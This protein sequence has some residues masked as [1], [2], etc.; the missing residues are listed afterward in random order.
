MGLAEPSG[1]PLTSR[2]RS[3]TRDSVLRRWLVGRFAINA[4][5][6]SEPEGQRLGFTLV[7]K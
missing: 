5:V 3:P 6:E 4:S 2:V 1:N 7:M